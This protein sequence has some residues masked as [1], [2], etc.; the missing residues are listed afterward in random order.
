[1]LS[2]TKIWIDGKLVPFNKA[3]VHV[4]SHSFGRG[5]ALFEVMGVH[6]TPKGP[7]VFRLDDH[8]ARLQGSAELTHMKLPLSKTALK[9]AVKEVVKAN[10]VG[11][12]IV[13]LI[14]FYGGVEF[15]VIPR[16]PQVTVMAVAVDIRRDI[17]AERFKKELRQ[18]AEVTISKWRKTD[19]R[20]MPVGA[21][22]SA[23]YVGGMVAKMEAIEDGFSM[24]LLLDC[25]GY[26]AEGAT[27]SFFMVKNRTLVTAPLG[28]VLSGITRMTVL[29]V[30]K[31]FGFK[32]V[33]KKFRPKELEDADEA[34]FTS[35]IAKLWPVGRID[36][37]IYYPTP[38]EM[39]KLVDKIIEKVV[40][41]HAKEYKKWL[42]VIK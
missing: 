9:K 35:S 40:S 6:E 21:K 14:C 38:G 29:D 15:E 33:E 4:L 30:A 11:T 20:T 2:R 5:S 7:A 26:V 27:E 24:P 39:T 12:G 18:P 37:I 32:T 41:G 42:T 16:N 36:K 17:D 23:N 3:Q 22:S 8:I 13:K 19:P 25:E 31:D 1:M 10:K 28:T 34:F